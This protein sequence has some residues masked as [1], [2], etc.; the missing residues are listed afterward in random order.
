MNELHLLFVRR[1]LRRLFPHYF[2]R[3][4]KTMTAL[5]VWIS[6]HLKPFTNIV[7]DYEAK[8]LKLNGLLILETAKVKKITNS[9]GKLMLLKTAE[10]LS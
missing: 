9:S 6:V 7:M 8:D 5:A 10:T 2:D 1:P 3:L 4:F